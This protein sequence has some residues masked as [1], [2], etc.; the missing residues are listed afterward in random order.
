MCFFWRLIEKSFL[1]SPA[2]MYSKQYS[3]ADFPSHQS[4][5]FYRKLQKVA[6]QLATVEPHFKSGTD[7]SRMARTL[8]AKLSNKDWTPLDRDQ[9]RS[10]VAL[11]QGSLALACHFG[12]L[13]GRL[14]EAEDSNAA[15]KLLCNWDTQVAP[16]SSLFS[17]LTSS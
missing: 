16:F 6:A 7:F 15:V 9:V 4:S 3:L 10:R 17:Y 11:L 5:K 1:L 14:A 12:N 8:L 2:T 13:S